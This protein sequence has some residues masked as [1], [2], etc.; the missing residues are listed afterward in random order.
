M[1]ENEANTSRQGIEQYPCR[2]RSQHVC[3]WPALFCRCCVGCFLVKTC[4]GFYK[5]LGFSLYATRDIRLKRLLGFLQ[6]CLSFVA[7]KDFVGIVFRHLRR[8]EAE[9]GDDDK[10]AYHSYGSA[11]DGVDGV[12]DEHVDNGD[13]NAPYEAR[14]D[15]RGCD[16]APIES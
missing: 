14:P 2:E 7:L 16:A 10:T 13:T 9:E 5:P 8:E 3:L 1:A 12:A 6:Y 11:V 4:V 15:G